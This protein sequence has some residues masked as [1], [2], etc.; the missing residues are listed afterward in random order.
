MIRQSKETKLPNI[1]RNTQEGSDPRK[2]HLHLFN[3][4]L[5][6][7]TIVSMAFRAG[8]K[9]GIVPAFVELHS[10]GEDK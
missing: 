8:N 6:I 2:F 5:L 1:F 10:N 4:Y 9:K 3:R 7:R